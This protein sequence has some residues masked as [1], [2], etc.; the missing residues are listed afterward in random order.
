MDQKV[1][2]FAK[3]FKRLKDEHD[4][5]SAKL[6]EVSTAWDAVEAALLDAMVEEGVNSIDLDGI[7]KLS[8]RTENFLSVNSANTAQ[9]YEYLKL[10]GNGALLKES[11]NPRTLTSWLKGH[12]AELIEQA[13][14][15]GVDIVE[16][17]ENAL[18]FLNA[19]GASY[20]TKRGISLRKG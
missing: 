9:F 6:K 10:S 2:E 15:N 18:Q 8:M 12:L 20:F 17:R 3:E 13:Q 14:N 4:E 19:K 16:A 11:V 1:I 5:L 7:G